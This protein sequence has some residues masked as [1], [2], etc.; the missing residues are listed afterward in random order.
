MGAVL[1]EFPRDDVE[2]ETDLRKAFGA[3]LE[4]VEIERFEGAMDL[5]Q[6]IV[7]V[8]TSTLTALTTIVVT[9]FNSRAKERLGRKVTLNGRTIHFD[10]L[11]AEDVAKLLSA[12][13]KRS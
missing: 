8:A 1:L 4:T 5:V 11:S 9:Y 3:H 13:A 6:V 7:P 10:G 2:L 12:A